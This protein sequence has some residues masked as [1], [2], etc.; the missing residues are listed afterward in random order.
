M[1]KT[2]ALELFGSA[3]K[4]R[5]AGKWIFRD[6]EPILSEKFLLRGNSLQPERNYNMAV[7]TIRQQLYRTLKQRILDGVYPPGAHLNIDIIAKEQGVSNSPLREA[8][9]LLVKDRLV[10]NRP[11]AG[12]YVIGDHTAAL[13]GAGGHHQHLDRGR[14]PSLPEIREN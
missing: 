7:L 14:L 3:P 10:E 4:G 6:A 2:M 5:G 13:P 12:M 8:M 11:N 9:T 1:L